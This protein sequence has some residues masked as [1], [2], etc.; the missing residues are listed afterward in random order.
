[1]EDAKGVKISRHNDERSIE[2][3]E[4]DV[5]NDD[6]DDDDEHGVDMTTTETSFD[7][8]RDEVGEM[9]KLSSK[10]T[11]RL[12]IWRIVVTGVLLMTAFAVTFTTYTLLKQ[13][14]E[15][16][17]ETAVRNSPYHYLSHVS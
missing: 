3:S 14:E 1:M 5:D 10:D 16:N 12:H 8:P 13:Q 7:L 6:G 9:R 17:F 15:D 4:V 2:V 11:N